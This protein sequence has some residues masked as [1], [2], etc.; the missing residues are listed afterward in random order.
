MELVG[1][2][3]GVWIIVPIIFILGG[4]GMRLVAYYQVSTHN[5]QTKVLYRVSA[6]IL[7]FGFLSLLWV[8]FCQQRAPYVAYRFWL[9][10]IIIITGVWLYRAVRYALQRIP[11]I[12]KEQQEKQQREKYLPKKI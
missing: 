11:Q 7:F 5:L 8:V 10:L 9:L 6:P 2:V 4:I 12:K 3:R 1:V